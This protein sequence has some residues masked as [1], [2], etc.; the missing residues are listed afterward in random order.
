MT[1]TKEDLQDWNSNQ[2]TK[3]IHRRIAEA[4]KMVAEDS[5]IKDTADQTAM[6]SSYNN[7]WIEGAD[8]VTDAFFEALEEAD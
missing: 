7:G 5:P 4:R 2:V 3:E 1:L 8:A 6:Q